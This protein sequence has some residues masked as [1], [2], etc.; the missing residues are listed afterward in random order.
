MGSCISSTYYSL[1]ILNISE[2]EAQFEL[3]T[4]DSL[5]IKIASTVDRK[6]R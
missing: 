2:K 6:R 4:T 5:L 1:N 3:I